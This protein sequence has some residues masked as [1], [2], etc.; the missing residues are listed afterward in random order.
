M[1]A[2]NGYLLFNLIWLNQQGSTDWSR[3]HRRKS[4]VLYIGSCRRKMLK[5]LYLW[6]RER[7]SPDLDILFMQFLCRS[8]YVRQKVYFGSSKKKQQLFYTDYLFLTLTPTLEHG[9]EVESAQCILNI[10]YIQSLGARQN[11]N[12]LPVFCAICCSVYELKTVKILEGT[13]STLKLS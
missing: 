12:V 2:Q 13:L 11:L 1:K 8:L 6:D 4:L 9:Y 10:L 3:A 7:D 5:L